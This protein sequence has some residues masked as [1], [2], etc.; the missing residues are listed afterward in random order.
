MLLVKTL[1]VIQCRQGWYLDPSGSAGVT[2]IACAFMLHIIRSRGSASPSTLCMLLTI[3]V[4]K[5]FKGSLAVI[6]DRVGGQ[7]REFSHFFSIWYAG[8]K[9]AVHGGD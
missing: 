6:C 5:V 3:S 2:S 7:V 8:V 9:E 4:A 1:G